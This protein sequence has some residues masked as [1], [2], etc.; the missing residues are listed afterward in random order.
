MRLSKEAMVH[1]VEQFPFSHYGTLHTSDLV[2]LKEVRNMCT[3]NRCNMYNKNW[4]C[5]PACGTIEEITEKARGFTYGMILQMTG[6]ME[7]DYDIETILNTEKEIKQQMLQ[8]IGVLKEKDT[9]CLPMAVGP[10]TICE[11][12]TYPNEPCR[13]PEKVYP[14]MEAYGLMV[15][16]CCSAAGLKYYYGPQT[17]T[18]SACILF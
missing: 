5:P 4:G 9:D 15:S 16:D 14:S 17:I 2:F 8:L 13:F 1:V 6:Q 10:C 18:F 3:D 7:D 11:K 12:C